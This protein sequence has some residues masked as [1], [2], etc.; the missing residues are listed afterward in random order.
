VGTKLCGA[1]VVKTNDTGVF[2]ER[3]VYFEREAK[4]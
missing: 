1:A 4:N 3:I 2:L